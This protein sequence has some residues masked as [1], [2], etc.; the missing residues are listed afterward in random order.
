[1]IK[2]LKFS[3]PLL[4]ILLVSCAGDVSSQSS[5][6]SSSSNT[7]TVSFDSRG[8]SN[9]PNQIVE[10][11][12]FVA[13]PQ[14][15]KEGHILEGW[16]TSLNGGLTLENKWNFFTDRVNFNLILH[17]NW[18]LKFKS[19]T[20]GGSHSGFLTQTG[21]VFTSGNN[22]FGQLGDGSYVN[23]GGPIEITNR[24]QLF[25]GD[26]V[27]HAGKQLCANQFRAILSMTFVTSNEMNI[28]N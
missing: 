16:Y 13:P 19:I 17:A 4:V 7:F 22:Q 3:I 23:N 9:V 27:F 18:R 10:P 2:R 1:M 8:G 20:L 12:S 21:R 25:E 15:S 11:N 26:K 5:F 14:V 28:L 6:E 24:I